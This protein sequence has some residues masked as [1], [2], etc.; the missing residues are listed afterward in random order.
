MAPVGFENVLR[1]LIRSTNWVGDAVL[2]TPA[3]R[4]VRKN[5][6]DARIDVLAKPWVAPVFYHNPYIDSIVSYDG[7]RKHRG[8][9]GKIRLAKQLRSSGYGLAVLFQNAFEAAFLTFAAGIPRRLGYNTDGRHVL[10]TD[11]VRRADDFKKYH[12][13]DYYLGILKGAGLHLDGRDLTLVLTDEEKRQGDL[14]L[15]KYGVAPEDVVVGVNPGATYGTAKRWSPERFA[16]LC[17]RLSHRMGARVVIFG[18]PNERGVGTDI[19]ERMQQRP[20]DLCGRTTLREA[21]AIIDRCRLFITNDSGLMHIAAALDVPLLAIFGSTNP[22]TTGPS[23]AHSRVV[24]VPV[25]CSPCLEP[26]CPTDHRCMDRIT[27][28]MVWRHIDGLL[29]KDNAGLKDRY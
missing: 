25:A 3:V 18:A 15:E 19:V 5:F 16:V 27:V 12:E 29:T 21:M 4:A 26:E 8:I 14:T 28:D 13:I 2:T 17:D 20:I 1:I 24:R 7:L 23:G 11:P 22:I 10:L 6:P 9:L